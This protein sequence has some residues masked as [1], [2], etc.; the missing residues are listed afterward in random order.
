VL[1]TSNNATGYD[2]RYVN[3]VYAEGSGQLIPL[4]GGAKLQI[5]AKAPSYNPSTGVPTYPGISGS[6]LPGVTL[7]GYKTFREAKFAG[8]FEGQS[9]IGLGARAKLPFRAMKLDSRIVIDVA[10]KW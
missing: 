5:V 3:N 2:V 8:S 4:S 1:D 10:H 6:A 7:A 9:T